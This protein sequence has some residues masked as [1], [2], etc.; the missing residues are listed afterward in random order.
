LGIEF[1]DLFHREASDHRVRKG[2]KRPL[3]NPWHAFELIEHDLWLILFAT[4]AAARG[5]PMT[6][7]DVAVLDDVS[8]DIRRIIQEVRACR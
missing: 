6:R 1:A 4:E 7:E 5:E 8:A 2:S 3:F